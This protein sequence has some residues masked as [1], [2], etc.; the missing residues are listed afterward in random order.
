MADQPDLT[1]QVPAAR[2]DHRHRLQATQPHDLVAAHLTEV[3][4]FWAAPERGRQASARDLRRRFSSSR[5]PTDPT[6][7]RRAQPTVG[8]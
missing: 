5:P 6:G 8:S 7:C 1:D 2:L 4:R 3:S